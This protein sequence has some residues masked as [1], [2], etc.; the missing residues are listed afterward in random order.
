MRG[1]LTGMVPTLPS[2]TTKHVIRLNLQDRN[3]TYISVAYIC[4][5]YNSY[6]LYC[7]RGRGALKGSVPTLP[8]VTTKHFMRLNF[9]GWGYYLYNKV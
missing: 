6:N 9:T 4:I 2:V 7:D 1:A 8:L 5:S 3:I